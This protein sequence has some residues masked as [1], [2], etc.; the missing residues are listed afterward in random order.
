MSLRSVYHLLAYYLTLLLYGA[1]GLG[2]SVFS[3]LTGWV[4]ATERS[5]RFFQRLIHRHLAAFHAWCESAKLVYVRYSGFERLPRGGFVLV[6][7]HPAFIDITCLLARLPEAVCIF[8][9]AVRRNPV[10]GPPPGARAI[11]RATADPTSCGTRRPRS[12]PGTP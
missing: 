5:E 11:S 12:R 9:P 8:K 4:P 2:L 6:A 10:M 1:G 7:N 3:L